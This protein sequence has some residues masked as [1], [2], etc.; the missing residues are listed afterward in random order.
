[1]KYLGL[2]GLT[3]LCNKIKDALSGYV[4]SETG[5]GLSSNDF[6][7][8]HK[9]KLEGLQ[10]YTHPST[11]PASMITQ[12]TTHRFITD[13]EKA[14]YNEKLS[15]TGDG[16]NLTAN[17][18]ESSSFANIV[19]GEKMSVILGKIKKAISSLISHSALAASTTM[20]GHV[21]F[22]TAAGTACQGN[23]IRLSDARTPKSHTHDDRYYTESEVDSKFANIPT[24]E[25]LSEAGK[26]ADAAK[27]G[28]ELSNV[29][30][31]VRDLARNFGAHDHDGFYYRKSEVDSK[32]TG[33][34]SKAG[35]DL[36]TGACITLHDTDLSTC[37][38]I[39][40]N[41]GRTDIYADS[42][43]SPSLHGDTAG[44]TVTFVNGDSINPTAWTDVQ[45]LNVNTEHR[46]MFNKIS[47]MFKNVRYLYNQ[48]TTINSNL[49]TNTVTVYLTGFTASCHRCGDFIH[50]D[51]FG[52]LQSNL[53]A[54]TVS[55]LLSDKPLIEKK[56]IVSYIDSTGMTK[57]TVMTINKDGQVIFSANLP[58]NYHLC[59]N[60]MFK[61]K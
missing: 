31:E 60:T 36:N 23:D 22:G 42:I 1:M 7:D 30:G 15:S 32:L 11:H 29:T 25:T 58:V 5:K 28:T 43:M 41:E 61:Y 55:F 40:G 39:K 48:I 12:D 6:T 13:T 17:F 24:D 16:S 50:F 37:I 2:E 18:T 52:L 14:T 9:T 20:A 56:C 46:S 53:A 45:L 8:S 57:S 19:T 38:S 33:Y 34:L 59:G 35:G 3:Y 49:S 21:K 51:F 54:E 26:P 10:N 4:K 27:V 44:S 47:I